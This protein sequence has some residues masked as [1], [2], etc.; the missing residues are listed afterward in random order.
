MIEEREYAIKAFINIISHLLW[1]FGRSRYG[2]VQVLECFH[3]R[4][5]FWYVELKGH[6]QDGG[7][8]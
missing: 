8:Y 7:R 4:R 5:H 2:Y 3:K 1:R 6:L